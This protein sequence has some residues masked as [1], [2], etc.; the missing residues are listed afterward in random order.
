MH[1]D[2][3]IGAMQIAALEVSQ[4]LGMSANEGAGTITLRE[5]MLYY[6]GQRAERNGEGVPDF[7]DM[8]MPPPPPDTDDTG[9]IAFSSAMA[10]LVNDGTA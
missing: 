2:D 6:A 4:A 1:P 7:A 5:A 3:M 10:G 9:D 8:P